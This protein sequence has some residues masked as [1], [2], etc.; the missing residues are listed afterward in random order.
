MEET[1]AKKHTRI[2]ND[3]KSDRTTLEAYWQDLMYYCLPRKA[4]ITKIKT[5]GDRLPT[6]VYDSTAILSNQYF[7]AGT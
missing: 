4:Y 3:L 7:A 1:L 5:L 2:Y 6:D